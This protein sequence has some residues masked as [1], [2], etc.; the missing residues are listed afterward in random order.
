MRDEIETL[1]KRAKTGDRE[2][3]SEL[4]TLHYERIYSYLR[5]LC[6]NDDDAADL[7]QKTFCQVWSSLGSYQGRSSFSTWLHGIGHHV[8]VDW[9]RKR[10]FTEAQADD[11][12]ESCAADGPSPFD[13]TAARE[14]AQQLYALVEQLEEDSRQAVHLHY[15]QGLSLQETAEVLGVATSTVKYR[16]R[17]ALGSLRSQAAEPGHPIK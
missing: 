13:D 8:Y 5:R 16:L 4:L 1:C 17:E 15:Y 7:T 2:A 3:A 14:M 12:W 10:N 9:R 6:G 11:W